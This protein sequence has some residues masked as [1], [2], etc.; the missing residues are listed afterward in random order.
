LL[1]GADLQGASLEKAQLQGASLYGA[2][3]QGAALAYA[4]LQG[5][6]LVGA[7]VNATDFSNTFLWRTDWGKTQR[8]FGAVRLN[9]ATWEPVT[10][11]STI[12]NDIY[13][14]RSVKLV[15][16][17]AEAYAELL[18]SVNGIPEGESRDEA[19]QRIEKCDPAAA[20]PPLAVTW[21]N[22]F[23]RASVDEATYRKALATELRGLVCANDANAIHVLRGTIESGRLSATGPEAP[24]LVHFIMRKDCPVSASLTVDD[25]AKLLKIKQDAEKDFGPPPAAKEK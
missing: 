1:N 7:I 12:D 11:K 5:A 16:W 25:K 23:A 3:L 9:E 4:Q 17:N 24:A 2:G 14:S 13:R 18:G 10:E 19:L 20:P 21:Q 22:K 6:A 8:I 15:P